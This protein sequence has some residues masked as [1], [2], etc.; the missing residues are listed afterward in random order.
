MRGAWAQSSL[1]PRMACDY[2]R[3][4][5]RAAQDTE[6]P[7]RGLA[8]SSLRRPLSLSAGG[9]RVSCS[10]GLGCVCPLPPGDPA[11]PGGTSAGRAAAAVSRPPLGHL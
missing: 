8:D 3:G 5:W 4:L 9:G 10:E 1:W 2:S 6:C 7:A 11:C